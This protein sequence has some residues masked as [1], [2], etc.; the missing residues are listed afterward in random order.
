MDALNEL[1]FLAGGSRFR[2]IYELLQPSGD[3][4]YQDKGIGF[5]STWFPVYH[6]L[7]YSDEPQ[8][9]MDITNQIAF[10]HITVKNIVQELAG[11]G[12][13]EIKPNPNDKRSK[14]ISLSEHGKELL[15]S[16]L[17][18]WKKF[19]EVMEDLLT[20]GHP[21]IANILS[22]IDK[23]LISKSLFER[24]QEDTVRKLKVVDYKPNLKG[25]F[26]AMV[27]PWLLEVLGGELE[28][29]DR[30]TVHNP[31]NAYLKA[32]G[33]VFYAKLEDRIVGCVALKRL[34]DDRFEFAKL[35]VNPNYRSQGI[36]RR[37]IERC[38]SRCKEN[39]ASEL[40]LQ[41]T[42]SM[43]KAHKLYYQLGFQDGKAPKSMLVLNRTEKI[44]YMSL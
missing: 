34:D 42:M 13:V 26:N 25:V 39:D 41:T 17:P 44:M 1:G 19:S 12:L 16:L 37:L 36:A 27:E 20:T 21:D 23:E 11:E 15:K 3:K 29:D 22:R 24:M 32:G 35:Y 33:F 18:I 28:E 10:T 7:A 30:Y 4:I 2:R 5:I 9:I 8:T 38:I 31:E 40:W 43:P 14:L 6:V